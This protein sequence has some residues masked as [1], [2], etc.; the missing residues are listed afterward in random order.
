MLGTVLGAEESVM[1]K[2]TDMTPAI[3]ELLDSCRREKV[4]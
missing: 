4:I 1:N 3:R 2:N